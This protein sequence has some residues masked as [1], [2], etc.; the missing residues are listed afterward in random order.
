PK[1]APAAAATAAPS[2]TRGGSYFD[3]SSIPSMML[4]GALLMVL[5]L[6]VAFLFGPVRAF[7]NRLLAVLPRVGEQAAYTVSNAPVKAAPTSTV[8]GMP[9]YAS[10]GNSL[11]PEDETTRPFRF[12]REDQLNKLPI[13]FKSLSP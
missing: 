11:H 8:N 3:V 12:I 7:L 13:L 2:P 4:M 10:N 1:A 9:V 6:F 5:I